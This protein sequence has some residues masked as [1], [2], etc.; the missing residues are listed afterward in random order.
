MLIIV[1]YAVLLWLLWRMIKG[2]EEAGYEM[3][4]APVRMTNLALAAIIT[5]VPLLGIAPAQD[6]L[7]T[8][9]APRAMLTARAAGAAAPL[10]V[11]SPIGPRCLYLSYV[12][13]LVTAG[14]LLSALPLVSMALT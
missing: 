1:L 13:L 14:C 12:C 4:P 8:V 5:A 7:E 6:I 9:A 2:I 10:L 11:V 3:R